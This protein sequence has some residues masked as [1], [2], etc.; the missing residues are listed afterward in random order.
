[1]SRKTALIKL[2]GDLAN[3]R[4]DV[5]AWLRQLALE[6]FVVIC[7]G[8]GTQ[9]NEEFAARGLPFN[10]GNLGREIGTFEGRQLA[11]DILERN[12]ADIQD[13]LAIE[14]IPATVI[15]PVLDIGSVLCHVNGDIFVLTAYLG[16]DK[17]YVLTLDS[18][19]EK[20]VTEF[21]DYPKIEIV[22]F[23]DVIR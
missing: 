20:K 21:E 18:R 7:T 23:P 8:G 15:I 14:N 22:G 1:M 11:R 13:R 17:I 6:Y 10:F 19:K 16:Y 12:Q 2:T 5:L 4:P 9:I 3:L